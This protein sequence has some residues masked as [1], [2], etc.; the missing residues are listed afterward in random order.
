VIYWGTKKKINS[1]TNCVGLTAY[2]SERSSALSDDKIVNFGAFIVRTDA[3]AT[4]A[5]S[6][7]GVM[8]NNMVVGARYVAK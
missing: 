4:A 5:S 2:V 3:C 7:R 1:R 8:E 6:S